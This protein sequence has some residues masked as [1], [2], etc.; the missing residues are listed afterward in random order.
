[1]LSKRILQLEPSP[2]LS[3]DAKVKELQKQGVTVINLGLGEPDFSTPKKIGE[4]GVEAIRS[5]FTHY[6]PAA[7]IPEL[8]SAVAS[9]LKKENGLPYSPEEIVVGVGSKAVLYNLFQVLC[10]PGDEVI[11]ATPTWSTY[12]E[13]IKLAEA[14]PV[15][16]K[17]AP[18]FKLTA[19]DVEKRISKK[20]KII[21]LNS[22]ANPTGAIIDPEELKKIGELAVKNDLLIISDEI[23]DHL[24][25]TNSKIVSVASYGEEIKK[26]TIIVNGFSKSHAMTGWRIGYAAGPKEIIGALIALQGQTTSNTSSIAQKAALVALEDT[27]STAEML[28]E[29]QKRREFV[30]KELQNIPNL[31]VVAPE[32]A[33]YFFV[34]VEKLLNQDRPASADWCRALL[35]KEHVAVVPGEAFHY[36]GYFRLSFASSMNELKDAMAA[37]KRFII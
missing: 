27:E 22:P 6:T 25:Y 36:P 29:F 1:M 34:S 17:L 14:T 5:G 9:W 3:L 7:G 20:S 32:G 8:R 23:Y 24:H 13:Q 10:D 37:L 4:A 30:L 16:I 33:F 31:S 28:R 26:R 18:P 12:V 2:T 21:L 35:E 19:K 11:L 15:E